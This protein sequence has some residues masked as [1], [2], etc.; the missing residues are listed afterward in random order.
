MKLQ[1][2]TTPIIATCFLLAGFA[3]HFLN[4]QCYKPKPMTTSQTE[5]VKGMWKGTYQYAGI[6]RAITINIYTD[7]AARLV[8]DI[9]VPPVEGKPD[10]HLY[11]F[12][13]GGE[14]HL[15]EFISNKTYSFQGTPVNGTIEGLMVIKENNKAIVNGHFSV[16][17]VK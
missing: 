8:C 7:A 14:F 10:D 13:D 6:S 16:S 9:D 17:K 12:C 5:I 4:A 2:F 11:W 15:K 3:P 1:F